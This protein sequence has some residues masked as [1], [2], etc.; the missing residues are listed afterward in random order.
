MKKC[1][2]SVD[3]DL[4]SMCATHEE[5][6][7]RIILHGADAAANGYDRLVIACR[8]TDV[9]LLLVVFSEY[10]AQE[11]WMRIGSTKK[12][13]F[14][15]IKQIVL[16]PNTKEGLLAF[17]AVT[18]CDSTS[19]FSGIG[20]KSAWKTFVKHPSLLYDIGTT[21][22]PSTSTL[23]SAEAFVCKLYD[24]ETEKVGIHDVRCSTF[25]KA[26]SNLDNLPPTQDSLM[27]H[28]KRAHYQ[29]LVWKQSLVAQPEL[30]SPLESG[31]HLVETEMKPVLMTKNAISPNYIDIVSCQCKENG[32]QCRNRHCACVKGSMACTASCRC[33]GKD[34]CK[35][36]H[37]ALDDSDSE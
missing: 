13:S 18:G 19:Q 14:V 5:A 24:P 1:I 37:N 36:T 28:L 20:K 6:D 33:G 4:S 7:T 11:I 15:N 27:L 34:W 23:K 30:P 22:I 17:H 9:L 10:L 16:P 31:W 26:K 29:T 35:N 12:P 25:R 3:R 32:G 2:S 21:S 8:D